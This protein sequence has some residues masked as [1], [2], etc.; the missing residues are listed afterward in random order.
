MSQPSVASR[1]ITDR[2]IPLN[3]ASRSAKIGSPFTHFEVLF[4]IYA[5]LF[6]T[7]LWWAFTSTL[8]PVILIIRY[9]ILGISMILLSFRAKTLVRILP[10]GKWL[11]IYCLVC[12]LSAAWSIDFG[13]TSLGV[14]Q[15][16]LQVSIFGLYFVS[17]FNPKHQLYI[18]GSALAITILVNLFYVFALP[19]IGI[20]TDEK[21]RGAW[22][23]FYANK[24]A[25]SGMMLWSLAV[26]YL[27]SFRDSNRLTTKL[28]RIG[29]FVSP[30]LVILSTSKTALVLFILLVISLTIWSKY[31]WK[32]RKTILAIDLAL[33]STIIIVGGIITEWVALVTGLGKDPTISGRTVIWAGAIAQIHL[34]PLLGYGF[35]AFW[36]PDNPAARHIGDALFPGF[37]TFHAHNGFLDILLNVGYLGLAVFMIGFISTWVLALKYAYKPQSPGDAWPLAVMVIVTLYNTTE[38]T[39]ITDNINWLFYVMA[40][41]SVRIWPR[42]QGPMKGLEN[43]HEK[44]HEKA[45]KA[46]APE[47]ATPVLTPSTAADSSC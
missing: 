43:T 40:Y 27:L 39:L 7:E 13:L 2:S 28:A 30:I 45:H 16:L 9:S 5:I 10:K 17:R 15:V 35:F 44:A 34:R 29:L 42:Q 6:Y 4:S 36:T 11:W 26:F 33:F 18:L 46:E 41:L 32:G 37:Y 14:L 3:A 20:H 8:G 21:F 1:E 25:F 38:S 23:G 12:V 19:S 22:K 47:P 24:N 31:L